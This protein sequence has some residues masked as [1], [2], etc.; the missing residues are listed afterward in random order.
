MSINLPPQLTAAANRAASSVQNA[1]YVTAVGITNKAIDAT[2]QVF[3][4]GIQAIKAEIDIRGVFIRKAE[5]T[6]SLATQDQENQLREI[7]NKH[8]SERASFRGSSVPNEPDFGV[9]AISGCVIG[10]ILF[11]LLLSIDL[12]FNAKSYNF[13]LGNTRFTLDTVLNAGM[14]LCVIAWLIIPVTKRISFSVAYNKASAE[15]RLHEQ[16][17]AVKYA[18][19]TQNI[20]QEAQRHILSIEQEVKDAKENQHRAVLAFNFLKAKQQEIC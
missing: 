18:E 4:S 13:S 2:Q 20:R 6:L 8:Q 5:S 15:K 16:K 17:L 10:P 12:I 11:I 9:D 3:E 19:Q 14:W 7:E 1:D